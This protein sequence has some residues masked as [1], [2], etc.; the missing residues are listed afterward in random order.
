MRWMVR[1]NARTARGRTGVSARFTVP[2]QTA[3]GR[4]RPLTF[5]TAERDPRTQADPPKAS[6]P[7]IATCQRDLVVWS[8]L[9]C[10]EPGKARP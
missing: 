2:A 9:V 5:L 3:A 8:L 10:P 4:M 6:P 7:P 1:G